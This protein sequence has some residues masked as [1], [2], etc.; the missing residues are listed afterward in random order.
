MRKRVKYAMIAVMTV[1]MTGCPPKCEYVEYDFGILNQEAL[2]LVPYED[3]KT[4]YLSHSA[5]H[6]IIFSCQRESSIE[7]EYMDPCGSIVYEQNLSVL[8][9]DYPIFDISITMR[10]WDTVHYSVQAYIGQ[11]IFVLPFDYDYGIEYSY[12][13]S[14]RL[15]ENWYRDVYAIKRNAHSYNELSGIYPDSLWYN[16]TEGVLKVGMSN[17]EFYHIVPNNE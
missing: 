2:D 8:S 13:D 5:G 11:S 17:D 14:L 10:K 6:E 7:R 3:G 9:P 15:D 12:F 16:T 1:V 4:Y